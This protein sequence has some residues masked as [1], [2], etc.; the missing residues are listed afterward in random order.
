M[1]RL[2]ALPRMSNVDITALRREYR[3][4]KDKHQDT[5]GIHRL[6]VL[7]TAR[8]IRREVRAEQHQGA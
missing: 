8:K 4:L 6:L 2:T 7:A 5:T 3:R 1:R